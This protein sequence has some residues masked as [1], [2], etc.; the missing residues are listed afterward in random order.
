MDLNLRLLADSAGAQAAFKDVGTAVTA[1]AAILKQFA[2]ESVKLFADSERGQ[3][4]FALAAGASTAALERQIEA[5]RKKFAVDDDDLRHMDT[6]LLRYGAAPAA[7]KGATEAILDY[8]AATGKDATQAMEMLIR[9]VESGTGSLGKMGVHFKATGD[10]S[11]DLA[12]AVEA[13]SEKFGGAGAEDAKGLH[14]RMRRVGQAADDV[15]KGFGALFDELDQRYGVLD[16]VASAL[17]RIAEKGPGGGL[18][19]LLGMKGGFDSEQEYW[20]AKLGAAADTPQGQEILA[21]AQTRDYMA[22]QR[23]GSLIGFLKSQGAIPSLGGVVEEGLSTTGTGT[24]GGGGGSS[25]FHA[26]LLQLE[27]DFQR[28]RRA[29][30]ILAYDQELRDEEEHDAKVLA[31]V[32]A[33]EE[34]KLKIQFDAIKRA[35]DSMKDAQ[36]MILAEMKEEQDDLAKLNEISVS[37]LKGQEGMWENAGLQLGYAFSDALARAMEGGADDAEEIALDTVASILTISGAV[38]GGIAG[39][40]NP[41]A[42]QAG[43]MI[44]N[45]AG[46]GIKAAYQSNRKR[47]DG[48]WIERFHTGGWPDRGALMFDERP[49]ILQTGERVLSRREVSNMGGAGAVDAAARGSAG[50][51]HVHVSAIDT[52]GTREFFENDGGRGFYNAL[53]T[54]RGSLYP[55]FSG[56]K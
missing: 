53:R 3:R 51:L 15:K 56:G 45:L 6:L 17:N 9:G 34:L 48:G 29:Q 47:H 42:V 25:G 11:K 37:R 41:A 40:G 38:I 21:S 1:A 19:W 35:D 28:K 24:V 36:R 10:F 44:G 2:T 55:L 43:T 22:Q 54:G 18:Q 13:L 27:A 16:K 7:I 8:A 46:R 39:E 49:A 26:S 23:A 12:A 31:R 52:R 5:M 30:R 20:R 14:G 4:Q 50:Q 33:L 32:R